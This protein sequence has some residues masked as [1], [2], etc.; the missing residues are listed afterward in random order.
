[1]SGPQGELEVIGRFAAASNT[2]LLTADQ[3][4]TRFVYKPVAGEAPLWDFPRGTLGRREVAAWRWA[5]L[6]GFGQV[7]P[8]SWVMGP[9]GEGS[10]QLWFEEDETELVDLF[11]KET[12]P[13]GWLNVLEG[14]DQDGQPIILAHSADQRLRRLAIFDVL[15]NNADRKGSHVILSAGQLFGVDHGLCFHPAP[16]LRTVL[17]GWLGDEL[18]SGDMTLVESARECARQALSDLSPAE[19]EA[20]EKRCEFLLQ[21]GHLPGPMA[22]GPAIPWPPI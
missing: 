21:I 18:D 14:V 10:A 5:E 1:M 4:G 20:A 16:K 13:E 9:L 2:T 17:W 11:A 19:I 6:S 3:S 12:V 8:T 7:P 15:C 22:A